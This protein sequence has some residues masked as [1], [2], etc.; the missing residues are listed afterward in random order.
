M[1]VRKITLMKQYSIDKVEYIYPK[2]SADMV[3]Y[4]GGINIQQKIRQLERMLN[5]NIEPEDPISSGGKT[6]INISISIHNYSISSMIKINNNIRLVDCTSLGIPE[7][8][9]I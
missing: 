8:E 1:A 5:G 9:V 6:K 3:E 7:V 4:D 2:T